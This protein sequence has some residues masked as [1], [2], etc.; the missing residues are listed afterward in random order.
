MSLMMLYPNSGC[1]SV[2]IDVFN[3]LDDDLAFAVPQAAAKL[4]FS[5]IMV[6]V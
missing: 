4:Y 2:S 1:E 6:A 3:E 5:M